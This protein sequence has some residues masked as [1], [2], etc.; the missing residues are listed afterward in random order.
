M[1]LSSVPLVRCIQEEFRL[2]EDQP[3]ADPP[4]KAGEPL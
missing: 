1:T 4:R 3:H 2:K